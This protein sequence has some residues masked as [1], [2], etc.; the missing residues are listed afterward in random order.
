MASK[1]SHIA[2]SWALPI[3]IVKGEGCLI[4]DDKG[5]KY[6]DFAGGWCVGTHGWGNKEM[7]KAVMAEAK[8]ALYVPPTLQWKKWEKLATLLV[9]HAPGKLNR[10]YR[11]CSGSEAV[12]F[13]IKCARA[14]TGRNTIV[15]VEGVYH[16]H[17]YGAASV[18]NA[19]GRRIGPGIPHCKKIPLPSSPAAAAKGLKML[20]SYL[21]QGDVAAFLSEPVFS[22][23]G[24]FIPPANFYPRVAA[25]CK[26]YG[27]LLAMDEV[28]VGFGRCGKRFSS[29]LWNLSPD[30]LCLGKSLTGGYGAMGATLVT[31]K[32]YQKSQGIPD[33]AT[34]GWTPVNT[35][36]TLANV[37][38]L[39][40]RKLW[41]NSA[42][43]G[44]YL[45]DRI[46]QIRVSGIKEVRGLGLLIGI[47]LKNKD[48]SALQRACLDAGVYLES[49]NEPDG[50]LYLLISPPL[51]LDM[52]TAKRGADVL[53]NVLKKFYKS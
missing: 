1:T 50:T 46:S 16:G 40:D 52:A 15:S 23:A 4:F 5:K 49:W 53:E 13:A 28:A 6:I 7:A 14:S 32:V 34:F 2:C 19:I 37:K 12:E 10:V 42:K 17:T 43:V 31:E 27:A 9:K 25:L 11:C 20:E 30:I 22:N 44:K 39:F 36:A 48:A 45:L 47:S 41:N 51:I 24:V 3:T 18:G 33:Y 29:E 21:K 8:H 26:K 35:A 38:K